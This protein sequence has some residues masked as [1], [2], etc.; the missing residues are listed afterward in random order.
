MAS[1]QLSGLSTGIDTQAIVQQLMQV[2]SRR[3]TMYQTTQA[4]YQNKRDAISQLNGKVSSFRNALKALSDA[5]QLRSYNAKTSDSDLLTASANYNAFEGTHSIQVKQ[6]ATANRWVETNGF[7]YMSDLVG[8][9][10]F[11]VSYNNQE[12][13]V[14]T[15]DTMTLQELV[16]K[17]N[18]DQDNTGVTASILEY[19]DAT[20]PTGG[21]YHLVLSGRESGSDYQISINS[22][23]TQVFTST[24]MLDTS[25]NEV[26]LS[27]KLL[28]LA[29]AEN[30]T[31]VTISGAQYDGT[32]VNDTLTINQN[33]TVEELLEEIESAYGD[34]VRARL[35]DGKMIIT[36][37]TSGESSL[38]VNLTF[39]PEASA[40]EDWTPVTFSETTH[41]GDITAGLALLDQSNFH[42]T[43]YAQDAMVRIDGYPPIE[44][45]ED[46]LDPNNWITRSS[47]TID[48][49]IAGVTLNLHGVT[50][51]DTDG[52]SSLDV[53]LTRNTEDLKEKMNAM[54]EAY[55]TVVMYIDETTAYDQENKKTGVL[56]SEYSLTS[57]QSLIRSP[58][59]MN[60]E[61]FN[62]NDTFVNPKDIGLTIDADGMLS[63]D[64][65][66]FDDAVVENYLDLLSVIGAKKTGGSDSTAV[67]FYQAG[68]YTEAG[69]YDVHVVVDAT[70]TITS[71]QIKL[72]DEDWSEARDMTINGNTLSGST[73]SDNNGPIHPENSMYLSVD[74]SQAGTYDVSV[75]VQQGFAGNLYEM[76]DDMLT[77]NT[78]RIPIAQNGIQS[79]INNM[80]K[81]IS[82]EEDRLDRVQERLT[83]Q[84][85]RL[86]KNLQLI[87]SQMAGLSMLGG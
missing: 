40:G 86:E 75:N 70:G 5:S 34:T 52:Y 21:R 35:E 73:E 54:V 12:F 67:E 17:I 19:K 22:S 11:I 84:Y 38:S 55:N 51:N 10:N 28:N 56:S 4:G 57:I 66:A 13:V 1:V 50:G 82:D 65:K 27:T 43:Q 41:G 42:E 60:A 2:E 36:D 64:E 31:Q 26:A 44:S 25:G 72:K 20:N 78:G 71:A 81:R 7:K 59:V 85:A 45:E 53:T 48:N 6:L 8:Q 15:T 23:N 83:S 18:N 69:L 37:K 29:G 74:T 62:D 16:D 39:E 30:F 58:L 49:L 24:Q 87:Q 47:N 76:V 80:D 77:T 61:G 63:L 9:G 46:L 33:S 14:N 79:R 32:A 3:L 68:T